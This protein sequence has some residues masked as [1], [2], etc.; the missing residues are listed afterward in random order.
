MGSEGGIIDGQSSGIRVKV[1]MHGEMARIT[2]RVD[3][4]AGEGGAEKEEKHQD[5]ATNRRSIQIL[6]FR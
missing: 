5:S 4:D 6:S 2:G 3:G 1:E